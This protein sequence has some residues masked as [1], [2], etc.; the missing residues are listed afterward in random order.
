MINNWLMG[1]TIIISYYKALDNLKVILYALNY[2]SNNNFEV[3]ISEDDN[4]PETISFLEESKPTYNFPILHVHQKEDV[5]FRKNVMMNRAIKTA[6]TDW[7]VFIDGDCIPHKHF[8]ESYINNFQ[9]GY[10]FAGRR[11]MLGKKIS[12]KLSETF[13][14]KLLGLISLIFSDSTKVKEGIYNPKFRLAIKNRGL[15]GCNWGVNKQHMLD[16][17]GFD[18]DYVQPCVGEDTDVAW[19]LERNGFAKKSIKNRAI[20]YHIYHPRSWSM[21]SLYHNREVMKK[22]MEAGKVKCLNGIEK[23]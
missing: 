9:E 22:K 2:Q 17:N 23:D 12:K 8:V 15:K 6:T 11:V 13:S 16:I 19:R 4:N 5:G 14:L 21:D 7:L 18:E 1:I 10:F 3:I 20:V